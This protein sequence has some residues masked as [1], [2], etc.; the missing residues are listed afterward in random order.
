MAERGYKQEKA[1]LSYKQEKATHSQVSD[2][3]DSAH[4][5]APLLGRVCR[6]HVQAVPGPGRCRREAS[7]SPVLQVDPL[8]LC[9][10]HRESLAPL[11]ASRLSQE[12]QT[13]ELGLKGLLTGAS[14][15]ELGR[16]N[17]ARLV[18]VRPVL[19]QN[20]PCTGPAAGGESGPR[21]MVAGLAKAGVP[22]HTLLG[23]AAPYRHA[24]TCTCTQQTGFQVLCKEQL[25][26][27]LTPTTQ[28]PKSQ[29]PI[30]PVM[31]T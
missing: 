25:G 17:M 15:Q 11:P 5:M 31:C 8:L 20:V 19:K 6:K 2:E 14:Q 22:Q 16:L 7:V 28:I 12:E 21:G 13:A 30:C 3:A 27:K 26:C 10:C 9:I 18:L 4:S 23:L 29:H 1:P 24:Q